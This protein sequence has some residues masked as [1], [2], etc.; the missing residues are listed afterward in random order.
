MKR[1]IRKIIVREKENENF[2]NEF[3]E[4]DFSGNDNLNEEERKKIIGELNEK[5][6]KEKS[7]LQK[8]IDDRIGKVYLKDSMGF[9]GSCFKKDVL[10]L[11][12]LFSNMNLTFQAN[13]WSQVLLMNEYQRLR[14]CKKI[15]NSSKGKT[16]AILGLA[17]KGEIG[18]VRCANSIFLLSYLLNNKANVKLF[19]PYSTVE[20]V[21]NEL[22]VYDD[23]KNLKYNYDQITIFRDINECIKDCSVIAFCNNHHEFRSLELKKIIELMDKEN[24]SIFDMY[25]IFSLEELKKEKFKIFKL[26]EFDNT[27]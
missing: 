12:F 26:G 21:Q 3:G 18:D 25:D 14:I 6:E 2:D 1:K 10:S 7:E 23:D 24:Q 13:Y 9:G 22:K 4:I 11:I 5:M 17:F 15:L 20:S 27:E 8:I 19:D 16:I